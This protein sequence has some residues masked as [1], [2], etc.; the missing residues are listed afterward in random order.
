M[1][2]KKNL[3]QVLFTLNE[4][5]PVQ[6]IDKFSIKLGDYKTKIDTLI[7]LMFVVDMLLQELVD[8]IEGLNRL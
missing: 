3:N 5:K 4:Q 7:T 2:L 6:M 8:E 1:L